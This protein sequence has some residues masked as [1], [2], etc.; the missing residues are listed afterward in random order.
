VWEKS[1]CQ[2]KLSEQKKIPTLASLFYRIQN[3]KCAAPHKSF[4]VI[5]QADKKIVQ[6]K[7]EAL[8]ICGNSK[9][10]KKLAANPVPCGGDLA[11][12]ESAH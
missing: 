1:F 10:N 9:T 4:N 8:T 5:S 12:A 2:R 11:P 6:H 7:K 3:A